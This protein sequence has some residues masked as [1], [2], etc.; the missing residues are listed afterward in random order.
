[1]KR[2]IKNA[3]QS[4]SDYDW[5]S[6]L[7]IVAEEDTPAEV[8]EEIAKT[9]HGY[10]VSSKLVSHPNATSEIID[11]VTDT[12]LSRKDGPDINLSWDIAVD[13]KT[14][15][16]SLEKLVT[17][18]LTQDSRG[19][20]R[21]LEEIA[22][23]PI[24]SLRL[25]RKLS[26]SN[27]HDVCWQVACNP[28]TSPSILKHL[29]NRSDSFLSGV[30]ENPNAPT[31]MLIRYANSPADH[32]REAVAGNEK[33]P[34]EILEKLANDSFYYV[35][36]TVA[37]NNSTPTEILQCLA[38]DEDGEVRYNAKQSLLNRGVSYQ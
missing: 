6:L 14:S 35:R 3:I 21:V 33:A 4:L 7:S 13:P 22:S 1:M 5:K 16:K 18:G 38:K 30:L 23:K 10:S 8:L 37:T 27:D 29:V 20:N 17:Y 2:Y 24:T 15:N 19:W 11:T 36:L 25:L 9:C 34:A 26:N 12:N 32:I 28:N 31:D